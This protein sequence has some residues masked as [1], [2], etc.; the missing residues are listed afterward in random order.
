MDV[1]NENGA[2][3]DNEDNNNNDEIN[4]VIAPII[5]NNPPHPPIERGSS[6]KSVSTFNDSSDGNKGSSRHLVYAK[7]MDVDLSSIIKVACRNV[8]GKRTKGTI[9]VRIIAATRGTSS[10]VIGEGGMDGNVV[11]ETNANQNTSTEVNKTGND[12]TVIRDGINIVVDAN[13]VHHIHQTACMPS[14][15]QGRTPVDVSS[16]ARLPQPQCPLVPIAVEPPEVD[17]IC[18]GM[19]ASKTSI[20]T[21]ATVIGGRLK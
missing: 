5:Q 2:S 1:E 14:S 9:G 4:R 21:R 12:V 20:R 7:P 10:M 8:T 18:R 13:V 11:V 17:L 3:V 15:K 19:E 6:S 16:L